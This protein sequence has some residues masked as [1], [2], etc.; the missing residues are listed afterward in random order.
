MVFQAPA[1][2]KPSA[3]PNRQW[4]STPFELSETWCDHLPQPASWGNSLLLHGMVVAA[5]LLPFSVSPPLNKP[6]SPN[7]RPWYTKITLPP[8]SAFQGQQPKGGGGGGVRS[9]LPASKGPIPEFSL[10]QFAPPS[11]TLLNAVPELPVQPT[12]LGVPELKLPEMAQ[13]AHWGD[14]NGVLGFASSGPGSRGG[15]GTGDDGGVGPGRGP[16][17]G[18]GEGGNTGGGQVVYG[19]GEGVS[20]PVPL[21]KPEPAYSEEARKAKFQGNVTLWIVVN[22]QGTVTDIR[23][24]RPLGMGLDEKAAEAVRTWRFKPGLRYG[25]PVAVRV[26]VEVSFRLF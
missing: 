25:V 19:V 1:K 15:I 21:Y 10:M 6:P 8:I 13:N 24:V 22:P 9:P 20:A 11:A 12:L 23:V 4:R 3:K 7:D 2:G 18:P 14:P 5:I 26:L 17:Y 16:G